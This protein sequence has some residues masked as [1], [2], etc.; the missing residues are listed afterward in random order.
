MGLFTSS[1]TFL[2]ISQSLVSFINVVIAVLVPLALVIFFWGLVRYIYKSDDEGERERGKETILW[3]LIA[4]FVLF[5]VWGILSLLNVAFFGG[6][7]PASSNPTIMGS[8]Y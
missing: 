2:S 6:G 8:F 3:S 4:I 1:S 7:T 5:S